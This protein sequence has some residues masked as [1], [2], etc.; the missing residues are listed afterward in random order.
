MPPHDVWSFYGFEF[1][2]INASSHLNLLYSK[3]FEVCKKY[4]KRHF[5]EKITSRAVSK[6]GP[7]LMNNITNVFVDLDLVVLHN[8]NNLWKINDRFGADL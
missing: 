2:A 8:G 7:C 1:A 4:L 3:G 5:C 6:H